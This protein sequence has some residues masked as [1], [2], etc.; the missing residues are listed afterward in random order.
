MHFD[1]VW[2]CRNW[3]VCSWGYTQ[4]I[5]IFLVLWCCFSIDLLWNCS[6]A[7]QQPEF[8]CDTASNCA[9]YLLHLLSHCLQADEHNPSML[10]RVEWIW[11][12]VYKPIRRWHFWCL[13]AQWIILLFSDQF[14]M[15]IVTCTLISISNRNIINTGQLLSL[16]HTKP[17]P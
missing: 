7:T 12:K 8:R 5:N 13:L 1:F 4:K 11:N 10:I 2:W 14:H 17:F 3:S 9:F 6:K 15:H 16:I